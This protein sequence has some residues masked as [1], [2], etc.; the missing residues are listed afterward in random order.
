ML[1]LS[2]LDYLLYSISDTCFDR[3]VPGQQVHETLDKVR[4]FSEQ[5]RSGK[6]RGATGKL[7][8]NIVAVGIGGSYLGPEFVHEVRQKNFSSRT[9]ALPLFP[10]SPQ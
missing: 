7:L 9:R 5:V 4:T 10:P 2:T 8:T 6:L 1:E 3:R